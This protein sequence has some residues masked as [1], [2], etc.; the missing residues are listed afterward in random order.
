VN[1]QNYST[2]LITSLAI[3]KSGARRVTQYEVSKEHITLHMPS[4]V[5]FDG[6]APV[7]S[8]PHSNAFQ[9]SGVD[10]CNLADTSHSALGGFS[11]TSDAILTTEAS[12][13]PDGYQGSGHV[14]G[15][16]PSVGLVGPPT[17][18][19]PPPGSLGDTSPTTG[20]NGIDLTTAEGLNQLVTLMS[21]ISD[22]VGPGPPTTSISNPT[23]YGTAA[24]PTVAVIQ[25]AGGTLDVPN[26]YGVLV[27][28]GT[29]NFNGGAAWNGLLLVIGD[30][31]V[32]K[33]GGGGG[34]TNGSLLIGN[35]NTPTAG[36]TVRAGSSPVVHNPNPPSGDWNGGGNATVQFDSCALN[37]AL[38]SSYYHVI[39]FRELTY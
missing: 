12:N 26:G 19:S 4:A 14:N 8:A 39:S 36:G 2:Y 37:N 7:F 28:E 29:L 18:G 38:S 20:N 13:R 27:V 10:A 30:G 24:L 31:K 1:P 5:T 23:G 35:I 21:S 3:T 22:Y 11:A 15:T 32:T 34:T 6:P 25:N 17:S 33:Q 16:T 9:V